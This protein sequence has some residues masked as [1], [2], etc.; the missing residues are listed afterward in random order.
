[1]KRIERDHSKEKQK[2]VKDKDT[3]LRDSLSLSS[4]RMQAVLMV[5]VCV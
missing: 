5:A 4:A 3:G 2:L 1:M